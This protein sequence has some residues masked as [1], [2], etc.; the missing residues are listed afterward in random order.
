MGLNTR[1]CNLALCNS[2]GQKSIKHKIRFRARKWDGFWTY[3]NNLT[4][5]IHIP[6]Y[7]RDWGLLVL[8]TIVFLLIFT[9]IFIAWWNLEKKK[10]AFTIIDFRASKTE[11]ELN[12]AR[13]N[14]AKDFH[15]DMG[16]RWPGS[17]F[18]PISSHKLTLGGYQH[19]PQVGANQKWWK[20]TF[21]NQRGFYLGSQAWAQ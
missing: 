9:I 10:S 2:A 20:A 6:W 21:I 13:S 15:D 8:V 19:S 12:D 5:E 1:I 16:I 7:K 4:F 17:Q 18:L 14:I 3:S 11:N